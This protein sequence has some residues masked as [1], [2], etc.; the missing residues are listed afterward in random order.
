MPFMT[1]C[2]ST[3]GKISDACETLILLFRLP[4]PSPLDPGVD[5][6]KDLYISLDFFKPPNQNETNEVH[7]D[8]SDPREAEIVTEVSNFHFGNLMRQAL[9]RA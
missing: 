2:V 7:E 6:T 8:T 5:L 1:T 4:E 3:F 9:S